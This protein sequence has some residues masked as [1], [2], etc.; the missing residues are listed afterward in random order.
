MRTFP[1]EMKESVA[2]G[3]LLKNGDILRIGLYQRD[4]KQLK[5]VFTMRLRRCYNRFCRQG[6][7]CGVDERILKFCNGK[8]IP[9][10]FKVEY[11]SNSTSPT[12]PRFQFKVQSLPGK[13]SRLRAQTTSH[14]HLISLNSHPSTHTDPSP[15]SPLPVL[16]HLQFSIYLRTIQSSHSSSSHPKCSIHTLQ[17]SI[18]LRT[19]QKTMQFKL[20]IQNFMIISLKRTI[21]PSSNL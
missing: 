3:Q 17:M 11:N 8:Q 4:G 5:V 18:S 14:I 15:H 2:Y 16:S 19:L 6:F 1:D 9:L 7:K 21:P 13:L 10:Q 12:P 20:R